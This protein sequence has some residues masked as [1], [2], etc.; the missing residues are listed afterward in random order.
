MRCFKIVF[1]LAVLGGVIAGG[2]S[3][4]TVYPTQSASGSV[5]L[6]MEEIC[7]PMNSG[8]STNERSFDDMGMFA[9][10]KTRP[11]VPH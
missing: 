5:N 9:P 1:L 11:V 4:N 8:T 6:D 3:S 10:T 7:E 2:D